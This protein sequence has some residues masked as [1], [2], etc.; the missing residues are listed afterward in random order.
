[1]TGWH[2]KHKDNGRLGEQEGFWG[3]FLHGQMKLDISI[4]DKLPLQYKIPFCC[5]TMCILPKGSSTPL[6]TLHWP[7]T[8][9]WDY[10]YTL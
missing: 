7:S 6:R 2:I 10:T 5:N 9:I 8:Y 3:R 4:M 1:M